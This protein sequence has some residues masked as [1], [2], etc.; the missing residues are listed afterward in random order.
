MEKLLLP[1]FLYFQIAGAITGLVSGL[2]SIF[3][4]LL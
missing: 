1:V 3:I 2:I 4:V